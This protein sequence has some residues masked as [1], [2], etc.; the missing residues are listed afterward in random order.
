MT[1]EEQ[2]QKLKLKME[3]DKNLPLR[4]TAT[5]LVFGEG[6]PESKVYFLGEAPGRQEDKTGRP[7]VGR[8]GK[9]L[10][11]LLPSIGLDR[12]QIYISN[13]V[14]FRPPE[15]RDPQPEEIEAFAPY[16]DQ[17]VEIIN[18]KI[19]VTLG[20]FSMEKFLPG[21]KISQ[22]HGQPQ[23]IH[24]QGKSL[25][26]IPMYHPAAALRNSA[27]AKELEKD[28]QIISKILKNS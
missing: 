21:E 13:I 25:T 3:A 7:F 2:L 12:R 1:K 16:V 19:V 22:V 6:N 14:H 23:K 8:A 24:W 26:V 28:F 5:Q 11:K 18:P 27:I 15:N 10:D 20:R 4:G 9:L 17:E